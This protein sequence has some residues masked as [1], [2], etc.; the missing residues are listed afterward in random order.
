MGVYRFRRCVVAAWEYAEVPASLK[1]RFI[2]ADNANTVKA[3]PVYAA[4]AYAFAA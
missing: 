4:P 3:A 1:G 2:N